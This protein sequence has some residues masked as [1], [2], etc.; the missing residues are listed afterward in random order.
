MVV[1]DAIMNTI[2]VDSYIYRGAEL[3]AKLHNVSIGQMVEKY[4]LRF[5]V[6]TSRK[7]PSLTLPAHLEKLGGCLAGIEDENDE[8]LDYL[9]EKYK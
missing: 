2:S 6:P 5:Q 9:L 1:Y 7:L 4:L 8:K 3:Y